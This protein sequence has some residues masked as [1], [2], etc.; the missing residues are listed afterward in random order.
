MAYNYHRQL[1]IDGIEMYNMPPMEIDIR[2]S[3]IYVEYNKANNRF[4]RIAGSVYQD[5]E[6][7]ILIR[8]A[9]QQWD[10]EFDIPA[11]EVIRVPFPLEEVMQEVAEK[12]EN[13]KDK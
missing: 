10:Q 11:G 13:R 9:N 6:L 2:P 8:W 3:D 12:I 5:D 4:D 7:A 1:I